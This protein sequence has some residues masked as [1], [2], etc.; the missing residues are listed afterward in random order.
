MLDEIVVLTPEKLRQLLAEAVQ[1]GVAGA[2]KE[3]SGRQNSRMN[4]QEAAEYLGIS[5]ITLRQWRS[6]K[7][8]PK[9]HKFEKSVRYSRSDLD[10]FL[11]SREMLT[12]DSLECR[13]GTSC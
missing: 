1:E 10:D 5:P 6:E 9:Y 7:K 4:E 13:H 3:I 8:G 2:I 12:V 11:K